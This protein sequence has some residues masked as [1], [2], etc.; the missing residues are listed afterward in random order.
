VNTVPWSTVRRRRLPVDEV[1]R[2]RPGAALLIDRRNHM[3]FIGLTPWFETEPWRSAVGLARHL[4]GPDRR[5]APVPFA[6]AAT[7]GTPP[8]P[9]RLAGTAGRVATGT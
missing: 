1:A 2:G 5:A 7:P 8:P 4:P 9:D 3:R 6:G